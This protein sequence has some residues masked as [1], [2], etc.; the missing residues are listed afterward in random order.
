[1]RIGVFGT[2]YVGLVTGAGFSDFGNEVICVDIDE[3]RIARLQQGDIPIYEPG[4][5]ELVQTNRAEGRLM[6]STDLAAATVDRELVLL[7]VG[8]PSLETGEADLQQ[9]FSAAESVGK[10]LSSDFTVVVDK[11]TVPVGTAERVRDRIA[12]CSDKA[13]AVVSNPE[14]LKEGSA[15]DDF[16]GPDRIVVGVGPGSGPGGRHTRLKTPEQVDDEA[17]RVLRQLYSAVVRKTDRLL[18]MDART[19]ELTKYACNAHLAMRISFMNDLA[20]LCEAHSADVEFLRRG[21]G[22]DQRIGPSFL[23]PGVGYGGSCFPK[24]TRA[25]LHMAAEVGLSL[26]LVEA[27]EAINQRQKLRLVEKLLSL[28]QLSE[29]QPAPLSGKRIAVWGLSFKPET[30]DVRDAP[31]LVLIDKLTALS[32]H[33]AAYDPVANEPAR[34]ALSGLLKNRASQVSFAHDGY[35]ALDGADA[36]LLCTE[37]RQFRQPDFGKMARRMRGKWLLDGRNT[38]DATQAK[39]AGFVYTAIGR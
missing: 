16:L 37:W 28:W 11:S 7:C 25:L 26:P 8:T 15:L 21:M 30:D 5:K 35:E 20:R 36:L 6:F 38:W 14:F 18:F 22:L 10:N 32:A 13:F 31:A 19:A 9:V 2:G 12:T 4:L 39:N 1:M 3:E 23:F 17:R 29:E 24:D 33:V 34:K 27:T